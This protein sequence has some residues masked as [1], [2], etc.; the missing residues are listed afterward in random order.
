MELEPLFDNT[1]EAVGDHE[2]LTGSPWK[3]LANWLLLLKPALFVTVPLWAGVS[4][5]SR[6][7]ALI[8]LTQ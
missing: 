3:V 1:V 2:V 8:A 7:E 5:D 4:A 6:P